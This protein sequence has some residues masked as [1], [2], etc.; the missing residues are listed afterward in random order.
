MGLS[1]SRGLN[2]ELITNKSFDY[3]K[4]GKTSTKSIKLGGGL[5]PTALNIRPSLIMM[6]RM[7]NLMLLAAA[8]VLD[9]PFELNCHYSIAG[10]FLYFFLAVSVCLLA[11]FRNRYLLA[12]FSRSVCA[13]SYWLTD[14]VVAQPSRP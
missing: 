12:I 13:I 10:C 11:V 7:C 3:S 8:D 14:S 2:E 5:C 6:L 9:R 1:L 4:K